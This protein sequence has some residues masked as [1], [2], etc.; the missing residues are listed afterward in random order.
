MTSAL[1]RV[2]ISGLTSISD[3]T[4]SL[5]TSVTVL[6]GPN[7]AGK[8]NL[9][10]A[11]Q[12]LGQIVDGQLQDTL[13]RRGG[14]ARLLHRSPGPGGG[15]DHVEIEIWGEPTAAGVANGYLLNLREASGDSA[16]LRETVFMHDAKHARP[17][18][19]RLGATPESRLHLTSADRGSRAAGIARHVLPVLAGCRVFHFQDTSSDAPVKRRAD[20][21]DNVTLA[22]DAQNIAPLL[23]RIEAKEPARYRRIV[24]TVQTVA[25]LFGDFFLR[26]EAGRLRLRWREKGLDNVF[27]A[28]ELSDGTLRFVCLATLLLQPDRPATI[29]LDEPELGLHPFAINQ[30]VSLIRGAAADGGKVILA[31]QSVTLLS[32]FETTEVAVIERGPTGA[33]V[34]RPN[35]AE[36]SDWL[37][38]Y[39]LGDLW[40]KNLLGGRPRR[41]AVSGSGDEA[42]G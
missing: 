7:G 9:I 23:A 27:S 20:D 35:V 8:S 13:V 4:L 38:E 24:R 40:E 5:D 12:L 22:P 17:Y 31:S 15:A 41:D 28:D 11:L 42:T 33:T 30:L 19:L 39:S 21:A 14:F 2:R 10:G 32:H 37:A 29:V 1:S 18:E 36:L 16:V 25:P 34:N 26:P 3:L 6:I